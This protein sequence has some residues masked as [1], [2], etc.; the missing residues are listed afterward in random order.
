MIWVQNIVITLIAAPFFF[1]IK[2]EP[3]FPPSLVALK[4]PAEK[5]LLPTLKK[6]SKNLNFMLI[7]VIFALMEGTFFCF[8]V[9]VDEI[10]APYGFSPSEVA[11]VGGVTIVCGVVSSTIA[12]VMIQKYHKYKL[13]LLISTFGTAVSL[14]CTGLTLYSEIHWLILLNIYSMGVFLVP[15]IPICMNFANELT[16]PEEATSV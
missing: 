12:G 9:C 15:I 10:L 4:E 5:K 2:D 1:L 8:G 11:I 16:F 13:M 6:I 7:L 3:E 14:W